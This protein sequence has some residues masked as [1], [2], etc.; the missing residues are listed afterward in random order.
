MADENPPTD[1][2]PTTTTKTTPPTAIDEDDLE[3]SLSLRPLNDSSSSLPS[4]HLPKNVL[5]PSFVSAPNGQI[6]SKRDAQALR[7]HEAKLKRDLKR[8]SS[9]KNDVV[10]GNHQQEDFLDERRRKLLNLGF[11]GA[12]PPW[13]GW[14]AGVV[15]GGVWPCQ[16]QNGNFGSQNDGAGAGGSMSSGSS[17]GISDNY[18][19]ISATGGNSSDAGSH[20]SHP[21]SPLAPTNAPATR[22]TAQL[23][24]CSSQLELQINCSNQNLSKPPLC[25]SYSNKIELVTG[26]RQLSKSP[27]KLNMTCQQNEARPNI[28]DTLSD[29]HNKTLQTTIPKEAK[30]EIGKP[31]KPVGLIDQQKLLFSQMPCVSTTGNGP[32]GKTLTGFL[33]KYSKT[34]VS[35]ICV[36]HGASFSPAG[37]VEHAGGVDVEYP[38]KHI[39]VV[40]FALELT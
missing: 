19:C 2:P 15:N 37:F 26:S 13:L 9:A 6:L 33:Y 1:E 32:N 4:S 10:V 28:D 20:S 12:T 17:S 3:L 7:R 34:E 22:T 21:H 36:C 27:E 25:S 14:N 16:G 24:P 30:G 23:Q 5:E 38:L 11:P 29:G 35:I 39:R 40:P 18:Q 31:P 8:K